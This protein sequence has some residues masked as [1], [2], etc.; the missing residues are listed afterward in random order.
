MAET[1]NNLSVV[2]GLAAGICLAMAVFF[3]F[4]F[5]IPAVAGDL[6]GHT[7]RK[8]IEKMRTANEKSGYKGYRPSRVNALRGRVTA[9][10]PEGEPHGIETWDR[11]ETEALNGRQQTD[12]RQQADS[13]QQRDSRQTV[14][15]DGTETTA[16]GEAGAWGEAAEISCRSIKEEKAGEK[17]LVMIDELMWIH[18]E[19]EI[20]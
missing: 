20:F 16:L 2:M 4:F 8:S 1:L 19:E 18:T 10:V 5:Q 3:W 7:A 15:S 11:Q 13:G 17:G 12:G 9:A 6:S 14:L